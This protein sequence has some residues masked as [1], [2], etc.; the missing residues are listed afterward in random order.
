MQ[1]DIYNGGKNTALVKNYKNKLMNYTNKHQLMNYKNKDFENQLRIFLEVN[2]D[3]RDNML[4]SFID[5]SAVLIPLTSHMLS[6]VVHWSKK[7]ISAQYKKV[8]LRSVNEDTDLVRSME[9]FRNANTNNRID[10][11]SIYSL[12]NAAENQNNI[13]RRLINENKADR[14]LI[15]ST[16]RTMMMIV[17]LLKLS[18]HTWTALQQVSKH[19]TIN[20]Q[21][22][23]IVINLIGRLIYILSKTIPLNFQN[24]FNL[25]PGRTMK[26]DV[27]IAVV[28]V[29]SVI[30]S[31]E[32]L[33][34]FFSSLNSLLIILDDLSTTKTHWFIQLITNLNPGIR[35]FGA[36]KLNEMFRL[37]RDMVLKMG[38]VIYY[39]TW[40]FA[41]GKITRNLISS[42]KRLPC[43][44]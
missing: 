6:F 20:N 39:Y 29:G 38:W 23:D 42:R 11:R 1:L 21:T 10:Y 5:L 31:R 13:N 17:V 16:I 27:T 14:L 3:L 36:D 43:L 2:P 25:I 12:I 22:Y 18:T 30:L 9:I 15:E 40:T 24:F 33:K 7:R 26:K 28:S 19:S 44:R 32:L 41:A 35:D 37:N 4:L 34:A 8:F